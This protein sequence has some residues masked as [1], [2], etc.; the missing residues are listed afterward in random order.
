MRGFRA[1][2]DKLTAQGAQVMGASVDDVE[3][4]LRFA[5][6]YKLEYPLLSD[7]DGTLCAEMGVLRK[8]GPVKIAARVTYLFDADGKV[9]H[10]FDKVSPLG[11][12]DE[13]IEV[14][15]TLPR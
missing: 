8:V 12:A 5:Q 15:A 7:T 10:V 11:H 14:L 2:M 9:A 4:H 6:K 13:V 1:A 3:S